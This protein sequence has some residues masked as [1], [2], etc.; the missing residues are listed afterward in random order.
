M[1]IVSKRI[2]E[3]EAEKATETR[4]L[5][6][7]QLLELPLTAEEQEHIRRVFEGIRKQLEEIG[8]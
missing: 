2:R 6:E 3:A 8:G 7:F 4:R 5:E 1:R